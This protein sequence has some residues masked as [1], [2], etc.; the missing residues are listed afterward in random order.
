MAPVKADLPETLV[1]GISMQDTPNVPGLNISEW[2]PENLVATE[3]QA[4]T[5]SSYLEM[6]RFKIESHKTYPRMAKIREVEGRVTIGFIILPEG[7][8][9]SVKV[10]KSSTYEMLD[11]AALKAVKDASPFSRPPVRLFG[12][13]V[14]LKIT[15]VFELT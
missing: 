2:N 4:I 3:D 12:G 9:K 6:V 13:E 11:Q 1:E 5:T 14:P 15:I 10:V 7:N 8:A